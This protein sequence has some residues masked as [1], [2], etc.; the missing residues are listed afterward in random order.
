V[1]IIGALNITGVAQAKS[2]DPY[3]VRLSPRAPPG[4]VPN[5]EYLDANKLR[6]CE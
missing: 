5:A 3:E 1:G 4:L 2:S 6:G